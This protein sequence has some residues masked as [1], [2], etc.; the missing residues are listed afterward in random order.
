MKQKILIVGSGFAGLWGALGAARVLDAEG[1]SDAVEI[2]LISPEPMLHMRPRLHESAPAGMA[3]P[4]AAH[5]EA[6]GVSYIQGS[7]ERIHKQ[8][9]CVEA[10][11]ASGNRFSVAYD[12]LLLTTGSK[13]HRPKVPGLLEH[14]F[15]VDQH[16]E[17][18]ELD[19]HLKTL[20]NLPDTPERNTVVVVGGGFT[21]IEVAAEMP[22]RLRHVLGADAALRVVVVEQAA[23]IGPDLGPGPRPVIEQALDKLNV[24]CILDSA[25]VALDADGVTT[26]DGTRIN[27]RTVIWTGGMRA[28]ALTEQVSGQRDNLGRLHVER[29]LRVDGVANIFAAGDVA[30]AA[31]DD[32]GH[33]AMMSCQHAID[34]GRYA[35]H[36]IAADLLGLRTK[37]YQ[38]PFY[39]TCLDLGGWGAVYTEGWDRQV[40]MAGADAKELKIKINSQWIYPPVAERAA[41]FEAAD[42]QHTVVA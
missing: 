7:V 24:Q 15:S 34:M 1:K 9:M 16:G 10:V 21:G 29:D 18:V 26:A 36:N 35:G 17:A 2:A 28:S 20:A 37:P 32:S 25:V 31:T 14:A 5:L 4:I 6:A 12:R 22:E 27:A 30:L 13:M 19:Q 42:P 39:V 11:D 3:T 33:H 41:L 40:K 23:S 38:Q 8:D